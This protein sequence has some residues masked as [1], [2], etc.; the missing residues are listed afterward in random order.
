MV[1]VQQIVVVVQV[2]HLYQ[3][4]TEAHTPHSV[5]QFV[6]WRRKDAEAAHIRH[7]RAM[8]QGLG[9]DHGV[10]TPMD[11]WAAMC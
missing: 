6:E 8:V 10:W 9:C 11:D 5:A 4:F 1:A 2:E 3:L 7:D